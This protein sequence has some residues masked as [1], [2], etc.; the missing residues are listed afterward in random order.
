MRAR[1]R[2]GPMDHGPLSMMRAGVV[3]VALALAAC[4][5]EAPHQ[6]AALV[7]PSCADAN[8]GRTGEL[9]PGQCQ[10]Q[11]SRQTLRVTYADLAAGTEEGS[12][13]VD[14]LADDGQVAQTLLEADVP[15]YLTPQLQDIDGDG[16]V[17]ILIPRVQ[18]N[19]NTEY[20]VWINDGA[21]Y[22][23]VGDISGVQVER[24][25]D[26]LIAV[27]A[28]SS[29]CSWNIAYYRLDESGLRHLVVAEVEA[30][31]DEQ[32]EGGSARTT[33]ILSEAPGLAELNLSQRAAQ[34]RFCAEDASQVFGP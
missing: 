2:G 30:H 17:D 32:E 33:C 29:C 26:G 15:E 13:S 19:V 25:A 11:S 1:R 27:P 6:Q 21:R 31:I 23:R 5:Q 8:A 18:G 12:I 14:V 34:E 20:G 22:R 16:R 4:G 24:T 7:L 28:R 10:L 3:V 9:T